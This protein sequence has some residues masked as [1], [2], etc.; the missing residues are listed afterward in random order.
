MSFDRTDTRTFLFNEFFQDFKGNDWVFGRGFLGTYFS[1][2]FYEW[3]GDGGD[4][5]HRFSIEIGLLQIILKGGVLLLLP[6]LFIMI[7]ALW[8]GF[9]NRSVMHLSFRFS[10]FL[11]VQIFLMGIENTPF[12]GVNYMVLWISVGII[13]FENDTHRLKTIHVVKLNK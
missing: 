4:F 3:K 5:Y 2:W 6:F 12:F 7:Y 10:L 8:K 13:F 1:P 9:V 11:L